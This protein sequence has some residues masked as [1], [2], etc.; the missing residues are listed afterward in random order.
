MPCACA[1]RCA[2]LRRPLPAG[3][4]S[5][6][7]PDGTDRQRSSAAMRSRACVVHHRSSKTGQGRLIHIGQVKQKALTAG[8]DRQGS[9]AAMQSRACMMLCIKVQGQD[10]KV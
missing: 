8:S 1:T 5:S 7:A 4:T 10:D 2:R 6:T 3:P 9:S